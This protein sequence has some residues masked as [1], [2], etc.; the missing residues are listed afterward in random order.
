[1]QAQTYDAHELADEIL[2]RLN[3]EVHEVRPFEAGPGY[4]RLRKHLADLLQDGAVSTPLLEVAFARALDPL[5]G[6]PD[7]ATGTFPP[8]REVGPILA[9][10]ANVAVELGVPLPAVR[11]AGFVEALRYHDLVEALTENDLEAVIRAIGRQ[12]RW[13]QDRSFWERG[14][15]SESLGIRTI[16]AQ[17]FARVDPRD[18]LDRLPFM[19]VNAPLVVRSMWK[20]WPSSAAFFDFVLRGDSRTEHHREYAVRMLRECGEH[21]GAETLAAYGRRP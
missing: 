8:G 15:N 6:G 4:D 2:R 10:L 11:L 14:L 9:G 20:R 19:K 18:M 7:V 16:S 17:A 1:M 13:S 3:A 21:E 5:I 12:P